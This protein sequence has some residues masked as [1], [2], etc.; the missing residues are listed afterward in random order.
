MKSSITYILR[1][2]LVL[3]MLQ[4]FTLTH[5]QKSIQYAS[6]ETNL[7][8]IQNFLDDTCQSLDKITDNVVDELEAVIIHKSSRE[9]LDKAADWGEVHLKEL[10]EALLEVKVWLSKQYFAPVKHKHKYN[11][12]ADV[13]IKSKE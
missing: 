5:G 11:F 1:T 9:T 4:V 6:V 13:A 2:T 8:E 12:V 3:A 7:E 10:N